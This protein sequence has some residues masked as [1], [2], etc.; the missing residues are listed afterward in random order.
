MRLPVMVAIL[1][2][3]LLDAAAG[4]AQDTRSTAPISAP[5]SSVAYRVTFDSADAR[6]RLLHVDMSFTSGGDQPVILALP[7]WTP[8][9][10]ELDYFARRVLRFKAESDGHPL[11]WDKVDYDT[12]RVRPQGG[13]PISVSFDYLA[14]T[15]DNAMAWARSDFVMFNGTNLF[16]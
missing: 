14:D 16:L 5:I 10:Y 13:K 1:A 15:L 12:W 7:A 3:L 6:R 11:V 2:V 9:S 4:R 8:G